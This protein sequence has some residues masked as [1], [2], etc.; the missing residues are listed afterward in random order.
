MAQCSEST[1]TSSAPGTWRRGQALSRPQGRHGDGQAG[2]ADH[3][4]DHHVGRLGQVGEVAHHLGEGQGVGHLGPPDR[5]GHRH[6]LRAQL[7]RLGHDGLD[8][9]PDAQRHQLVAVLF[10]P[11]HIEGLRADRTRRAG[12]G[13][14]DHGPSL[15]WLR[16]GLASLGQSPW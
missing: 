2:E 13:D 5:V 1:G 3:A 4:V 7:A 10:G 15:P 16:L 12:N 8:R 14:A 6:Q 11:D 9:R